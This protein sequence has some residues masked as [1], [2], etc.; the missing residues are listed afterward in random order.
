MGTGKALFVVVFAEI[1]FG[2]AGWLYVLFRIIL[3]AFTYKL[4]T[5]KGWLREVKMLFEIKKRIMA[6]DYPRFNPDGDHAKGGYGDVAGK[7]GTAGRDAGTAGAQDAASSMVF[8]GF[9]PIVSL[10]TVSFTI[11]CDFFADFAFGFFLQFLVVG[12]AIY[13]AEQ[14][15]ETKKASGNV[16]S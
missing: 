16:S 15:L 13:I 6:L 14:A 4:F 1:F 8:E 11:F 12:F 3:S 5:A 9:C 7:A 2:M 10:F